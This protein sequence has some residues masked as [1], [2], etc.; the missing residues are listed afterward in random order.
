MRIRHAEYDGLAVASSRLITPHL[1]VKNVAASKQFYTQ[2]FGFKLRYETSRMAFPCTSRWTIT[3]NWR[4]CSCRERRWPPDIGADLF[5][6]LR[7]HTSYFYLYVDDVDA[8]AA[9][10][11]AAG[12]TVLEPPRDAPWGI[13]SPSSRT[14]T[15]TT[16]AWRR[17]R[18]PG[19]P[20]ARPAQTPVEVSQVRIASTWARRPAGR[21]STAGFLRRQRREQLQHQAVPQVRVGPDRQLPGRPRLPDV[22]HSS[23]SPPSAKRTR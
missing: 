5:A 6:D 3:A 10:A 8:V 18:E 20:D 11:R 9:R 2:S 21:P 12:G 23:F 17:P 19:F 1:T 16:G 14:S 15:A 22:T 7:Q 4:S 13:G